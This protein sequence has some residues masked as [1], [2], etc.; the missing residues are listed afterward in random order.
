MLESLQF[1]INDKNF[2][3]STFFG[4]VSVK[5]GQLSMMSPDGTMRGTAFQSGVID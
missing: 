5:I 2:R 3:L 4:K 1:S